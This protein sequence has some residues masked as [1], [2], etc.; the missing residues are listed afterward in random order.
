M[1]LRLYFIFY[2]SDRKRIYVHFSSNL[3]NQVKHFRGTFVIRGRCLI[4][5]GLHL[6]GKDKEPLLLRVLEL[7]FGF[8]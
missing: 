4:Q 2:H 1:V 5:I 3:L 7:A 6:I 8:F